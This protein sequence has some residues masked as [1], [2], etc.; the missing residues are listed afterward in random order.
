MKTMENMRRKSGR[1]WI[2]S[3]RCPVCEMKST[4][5]PISVVE[6]Y[7]WRTEP[8]AEKYPIHRW[9]KYVQT[10][11]PEFVKYIIRREKITSEDLIIDPCAGTGTTLVEAKLNN[12]N[13]VGVEAIDFLAFVSRVKT[14]WDVDLRELKSSSIAV[15]N[16]A[17]RMLPIY[18][19]ALK[20]QT[21][22]ST[23]LEESLE[24]AE[25]AIVKPWY[26]T[27]LTRKYIDPEPLAELLALKEAILA[28]KLEE[29]I[30]SL[31]I[32]ALASIARPVSNLGFGPEIGIKK[33]SSKKNRIEVFKLFKQKIDIIIEDL[34][35]VQ[36]NPSNASCEVYIA[37]SREL[38]K[39]QIPFDYHKIHM[40]FSPPYPQDHDYTR[41]VLLEATLL[42]FFKSQQDIRATKQRMIRASTRGIYSSDND[43]CLVAHIKEIADLVKQI[44]KR[45][46]ETRG[47]SGFEKLYPKLV[48]EYFGGM[49]RLLSS[50][51]NLM[52][53]GGTVTLLVADSHAF[54]MVHIETAKL[55]EKIG[56]SIGFRSSKIEV[57]QYL[58]STAH[59]YLIP[60]YI[61][62]LYK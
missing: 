38:H 43:F 48:G 35:K 33:K 46:K 36:K 1:Y 12:I 21:L 26:L 53:R 34:I 10:Y 18:Q 39:L 54:K 24:T 32:L 57:W 60:E 14:V 44:E 3:D 5:L 62:T 61:L 27:L 8:P 19:R 16:E 2:T 11:S 31:L 55:L 6:R 58:R 15:F 49:Y 42:D 37:D 29:K 7:S 51:Y 25:T 50:A 40:I 47:T 22:T 45:V 59:K 9:F 17:I 41:E 28:C 56:L 13:C 23:L 52:D 4:S 30:K 20:V